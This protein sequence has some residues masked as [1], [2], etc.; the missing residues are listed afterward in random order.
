[1]INSYTPQELIIDE[2]LESVHMV[3]G[4]GLEIIKALYDAGYVILPKTATAAMRDTL[5]GC[6]PGRVYADMVAAYL[7]ETGLES[8]LST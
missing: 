5:Y 8:V 7:K 1:M 2:R 6:D 4:E 3:T